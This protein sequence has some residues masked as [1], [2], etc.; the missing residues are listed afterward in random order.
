MADLFEN[1]MGLCGFEFVEFASPVAGLI[2]PLL[3]LKNRSKSKVF[4]Y[5]I[6]SATQQPT[7]Y[8]LITRGVTR[9]LIPMLFNMS[10]SVSAHGVELTLQ[11]VR[12]PRQASNFSR[13][14]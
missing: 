14:Q 4:D 12:A 10:S 2:E 7:N 8:K 5:P 6:T 13:A 11:Q 3:S 9:F 1:P